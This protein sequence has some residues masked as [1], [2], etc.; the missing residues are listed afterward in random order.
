MVR[1]KGQ[2]DTSV[3]AMSDRAKANHDTVAELQAE[4]ARL[5]AL[6]DSRSS[7]SRPRPQHTFTQDQ[8]PHRGRP[9]LSLVDPP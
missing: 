8:D 5:I 2:V 6:L 1:L 9:C 7:S 4:N 3:A